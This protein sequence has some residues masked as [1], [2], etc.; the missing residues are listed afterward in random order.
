MSI[1]SDAL[2]D[3]GSLIFPPCCPVC[4]EP[5]DDGVEFICPMCRLGAPL[6]GF[7]YE[8]HNPLFE[9]FWGQLP[10]ERATALLFFRTGSGWQRLIHDFKYRR[11][12]R[13]AESMGEWLGSELLSSDLYGDVDLI[14]PIPLHPLRRIWR[15]YNQSEY[16]A[17]GVA[18]KMGVK[19]DCHSVVRRRYNRTQVGSQRSQRWDNVKG[20]FS[21]RHPERL[22]GK[23]ILL[24]D[25]VITTGATIVSCGE[26][27]LQAVPDCKISVASLATVVDRQF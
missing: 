8:V 10:L 5:L 16:I 7:S 21:V 15:G 2:S 13:L 19:L 12:W 22:S 4:G 9:S 18:R 17:K 6:T 11:R 1:L 27:I 24:V 26:S 23:H 3:I 20:I 14:L 25:D